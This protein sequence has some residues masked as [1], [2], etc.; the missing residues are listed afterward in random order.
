MIKYRPVRGSLSASIKE[1]R[2]FSTMEEMFHF[3][4]D[5]AVRMA[6]YTGADLPDPDDIVIAGDA[7]DNL[8]TGYKNERSVMFQNIRCIGYCGE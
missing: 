5:M 8:I 1:E 7:S 6:R 3:L 4:Y 2:T